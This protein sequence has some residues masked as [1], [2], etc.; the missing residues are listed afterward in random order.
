M[1]LKINSVVWNYND[2]FNNDLRPHKI[3]FYS[4]ELTCKIIFFNATLWA[5]VYMIHVIVYILNFIWP[6]FRRPCPSVVEAAV[7]TCQSPAV[8]FFHPLL[9]FSGNIVQMKPTYSVKRF[10]VSED[11]ENDTQNKT[12]RLRNYS[13]KFFPITRYLIFIFTL[14]P[15]FQPLFQMSSQKEILFLIK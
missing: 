1:Q 6:V 13:Y 15:S 14:K 2:Q 11:E 4:G 5:A 8:S 10:I 7:V 9:A 12:S 3:T